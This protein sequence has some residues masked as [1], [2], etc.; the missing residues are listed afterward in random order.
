MADINKVLGASGAPV[1]VPISGKNYKLQP[2]TKKIQAEFEEW[3]KKK[4]R[5][6]IYAQKPDLTPDE[7][8]DVLGRLA[9]RCASGRYSFFGPVAEKAI[10]NPDGSGAM[11]LLYL[12][13]HKHQPTL[14]EGDVVSLFVENRQEFTSALKE[15]FDNTLAAAQK[16]AHT[17]EVEE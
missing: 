3:L 11:Q 4:A 8:A 16:N 7:F 17:P 9:E 6:E 2:L 5:A 15:L 1:I 12:L 14:S 13:M 10:R